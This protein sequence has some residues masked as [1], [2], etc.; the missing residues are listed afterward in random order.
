MGTSEIILSVRG[1]NNL[2]NFLAD[3]KF[4][5]ADCGDVFPGVQKCRAHSG[6]LTAFA[7]LTAPA[8]QAVQSALAA[9]PGFRIVL[10][11]HSLGG[12]L[13]TLLG[14]GM[15]MSAVV[16]A[17]G[18]DIYTYGSPR[19]GNA[20]L[21]EFVNAQPGSIYR[22]GPARTEISRILTWAGMRRLLCKN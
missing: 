7:D 21:L 12:A 3:A 6:F 15:K 2:E 8:A 4:L 20:A 5:K 16:A 17:A 18:V 11:G 1:T 13:A 22:V 9:H 14:A 10:T 19:V